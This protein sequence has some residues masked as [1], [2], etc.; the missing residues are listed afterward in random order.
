VF[1]S[2]ASIANKI[3]NFNIGSVNF[4]LIPGFDAGRWVLLFVPILTFVVYFATSK[5]NRKIM[6]QPAANA[7]ADER[8]VACSNNMMDITMPAMS[9]FF[10]FMV[11]AL[12]GVYWVFRSLISL[13]KQFILSRIMP[14]PTFT[15]ED[16]KAAA[17]EMAGKQHAVK[18]SAN[19]GKV[20]SLHFIDDEDFDDTRARG[21]A[22][23][24][25]IE[26]QEREE[27][28]AKANGKTPF[29]ATP[30]KEDKKNDDENNTQE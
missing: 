30:M 18:K 20:R 26:E 10:T 28:A 3:P 19:V 11:P 8:Q 15:E 25:A 22:R 6:Y 7:G 27:K 5:I 4:G 29:D 13:L 9:T 2:F 12:I 24:A 21:E 1:D 23:R 14:L 16:Y 17:R